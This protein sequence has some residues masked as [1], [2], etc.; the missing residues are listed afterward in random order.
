MIAT[1]RVYSPGFGNA[2]PVSTGSGLLGA[3]PLATY[4]G[5][6]REVAAAVLAA[7]TRSLRVALFSFASKTKRT[8]I[9]ARLLEVGPQ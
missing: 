2:V 8:E 1:D 4:F 6:G 7:D 9:E 3:G 5:L